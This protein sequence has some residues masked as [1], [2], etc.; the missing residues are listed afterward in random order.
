MKPP[1]VLP[2]DLADLGDRVDGTGGRRAHGSLDEHG[3]AA[4]APVV[5]DGRPQRGGVH[6]LGDR[7]D[8]DAADGVLA[9][10][11]HHRRLQQGRVRL[12]RPVDRVVTLPDACRARRTAGGA[13][14]CRQHGGE[15]G[16]RRGVLD[17]AATTG[18][19]GPAAEVVEGLGQ[20]ESL[21]EPVE[22]HLLELGDRR[23]G[24]PDHPLGADAAA[25]Q[26]AEHSRRRGVGREVGEVP[27]VLPMGE[28]RHDN[29][30]EVLQYRRRRT[31]PGPALPSA[32]GP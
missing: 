31:R 17:D 23:A 19:T 15:G 26:V 16:R 1:G 9:E 2:R 14:Q 4:R 29:P 3:R 6:G 10:P 11:A 28:S 25:D 21:G 8:L 27:R 18:R 30:V 22:D 32:A 5:V 13:M 12:G 20:A 7:V 24:G